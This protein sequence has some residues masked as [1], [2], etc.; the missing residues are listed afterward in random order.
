MGAG[1]PYHHHQDL[2]RLAEA[3]TRPETIIVQD[4]M[5]TA[6]AQRAD[7]VL[8]ATTSIERDD[9]AGNKRSDFILAMWKAIEPLGE[10]RSESDIFNVI[11][12]QLGVAGRFNEGRDKMGWLRHLYEASRSDA[13]AHEALSRYQIGDLARLLTIFSKGR[14][15][16]DI[17]HGNGVVVLVG[18][19]ENLAGRVLHEQLGIR[20]GGQGADDL[21]GRGVDYLDCVVVANRDQ[22]ELVV[23]RNFDAPRALADLDGLGDGSAARI[24][25]RNGVCLFIGDIGG[26]RVGRH[27]QQEQNGEPGR[28]H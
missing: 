11:A 10:S 25:H 1:N 21:L 17:D 23:A 2:N 14:A 9:L 7:I 28:R 15:A 19:V 13:S 20:P 5:F 6:T 24:D 3:W 27:C 12:G 22:Y 16:L 4:P 8:P 18:N 26:K